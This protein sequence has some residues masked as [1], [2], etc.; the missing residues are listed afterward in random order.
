ME[1]HADHHF[2]S[3]L[4]QTVVARLGEKRSRVLLVG[5]I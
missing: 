4:H 1:G 5:E 3:A 2:P